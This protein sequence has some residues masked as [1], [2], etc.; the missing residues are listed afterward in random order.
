M[1][2]TLDEVETLTT[3]TSFAARLAD[4]AK[5]G[6][7]NFTAG[8]QAVVVFLMGAWPAIVIGAA[9]GVVFLSGPPPRKKRPEPK[10]TQSDLPR[11]EQNP[12]K[13]RKTQRH[14]PRPVVLYLSSQREADARQVNIAG[15]AVW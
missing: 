13:F 8:A 5:N 1:N 10:G 14:S 15:G 4:A 2:I 12:K 6:W 9:C 7:S 3:G 11:P